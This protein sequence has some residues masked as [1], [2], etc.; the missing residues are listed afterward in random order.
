MSTRRRD[1]L[2]IGGLAIAGA[3]MPAVLTPAQT[4]AGS[5][6][7]KL[8][9][10]LIGCGG[11][12]TGAANQ[13][14]KAD[15]DVVL[16]AM[17]DVFEDKLKKSLEN[18]TK[19][20]GDKVKVKDKRRFIGFDAYKKV[21]ESD[22]DVVLLATPPGFR[23]LHLE[24]AVDADKHVFCEKPVAV[25]A[26]GIRKVLEAVRKSKE[27]KLSLV[28]GFCWRHHSPKRA[29]FE[30]INEGAVGE[31]STIYNSYNTSSLWSFPRESGWNDMQYTLRNWPYYTWLSGDHIVEQAVHCIDKIGRASCRARVLQY[32]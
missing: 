23:P 10:G 16:H 27:K 22:V 12:G 29:I 28:S 20:H 3:A 11:R 8:K 19:I 7:K 2:K 5:R 13:A 4:F 17:G 26:P 1:F 21:L 6:Q 31:I 14:L 32:V 15:P 24:A 9:I 18:L 25:D 30:K